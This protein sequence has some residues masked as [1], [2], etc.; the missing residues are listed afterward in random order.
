MPSVDGRRVAEGV[1]QKSA[2]TPVI[3]LTGWGTRMLADKETPP[4]VDR[5]LGKPP[6]LAELRLAIRELLG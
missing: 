1:K 6:R 3:M 5:V 4:H 2:T